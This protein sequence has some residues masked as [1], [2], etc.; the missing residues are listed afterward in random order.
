MPKIKKPK[1]ITGKITPKEIKKTDGLLV[2]VVDTTGRIVGKVSL[3]EPIFGVKI[4]ETLLAQAV[5]VYHANN[6]QGTQSTKTRSQV[7]GSTKK[8]YRQKGTGR[9]RH[10]DKKAPIFIGGGIAHGPKPRDFSLDFPKKMRRKALFMGLS[11]KLSANTLTVLS[12][13]EKISP[14]TSEMVHVLEELKLRNEKKQQ[15]LLIVTPKKIENIILS[16]R[17]I[18]KLSIVSADTLNTFDVLNTNQLILMKD[19]IDVIKS[20]FIR[21]YAKVGKS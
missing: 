2:S 9:A 12:G 14:K 15:K 17:N 21:D 18:P 5:R 6:R 10:G 3:P 16:G 7:S 1:T 11:M 13:L 8:I 20:T 19:A 4:N